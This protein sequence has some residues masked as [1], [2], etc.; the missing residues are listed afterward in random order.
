MSLSSKSK[1]FE[2]WSI[3]LWEGII[4]FIIFIIL[5]HLPMFYTSELQKWWGIVIRLYLPMVVLC[6]LGYVKL[7]S[8]KLIIEV[9]K[10]NQREFIYTRNNEQLLTE[11]EKVKIFYLKSLK[12]KIGRILRIE[13]TLYFIYSKNPFSKEVA[14]QYKSKIEELQDIIGNNTKKERIDLVP[15]SINLLIDVVPFII[16]LLAILY[17]IALF[18]DNTHWFDFFKEMFS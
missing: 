4:V 9:N 13:G 7:R 8:R 15:L 6:T 10:K 5:F 14:K 17:L 12:G 11:F 1:T 3:S 16:I 2:F 18:T